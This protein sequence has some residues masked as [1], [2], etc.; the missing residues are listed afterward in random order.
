MPPT[1]IQESHDKNPLSLDSLSSYK[2]YEI[3]TNTVSHLHPDN[4][5]IKFTAIE[6]LGKQKGCLVIELLERA[7][8]VIGNINF[9]KLDLPGTCLEN[10]VQITS[11][12]INAE[13]RGLTLAITAYELIANRYLV[14]SDKIQTSDGAALWKFKVGSSSKL[15]VYVVLWKTDEMPVK[16]MDVN[17]VPLI[18]NTTKEDLEPLIWGL[19]SPESKFPTINTHPFLLRNDT[20]LVAVNRI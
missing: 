10:G 8:S 3:F 5:P 19:E 12:Y 18:Y 16:L 2:H 6:Y 17:D 15:D 4:I 14:V 9:N 13:Y 1:I 20:L 11:V 7:S